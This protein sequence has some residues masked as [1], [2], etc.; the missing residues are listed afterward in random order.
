MVCNWKPE[1]F[2]QTQIV[3]PVEI[4]F[5]IIDFIIWLNKTEKKSQKLKKKSKSSQEI[6]I[7]DQEAILQFT[8]KYLPAPT[9]KNHKQSGKYLRNLNK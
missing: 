8:T 2:L 1:H 5:M 3:T 9:S 7:S 6:S 4:S